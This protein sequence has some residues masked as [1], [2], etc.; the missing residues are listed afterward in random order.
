MTEHWFDPYTVTVNETLPEGPK[1]EK[2]KT[3]KPK[4]KDKKDK[5]QKS[6]LWRQRPGPSGRRQPRRR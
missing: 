1:D 4:P 5:K 2:V 6:E 3:D